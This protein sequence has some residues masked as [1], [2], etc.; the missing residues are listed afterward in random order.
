MRSFSLSVDVLSPDPSGDRFL[1]EQVQTYYLVLDDLPSRSRLLLVR[2]L[3]GEASFQELA[4]E[5]DFPSADAA[6]KAYAKA[7]ARLLIELRRRG[8]SALGEIA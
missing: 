5:L 6:R 4:D 1:D 8:V 7:H 3:G 2:R